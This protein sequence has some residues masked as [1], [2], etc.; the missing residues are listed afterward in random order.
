M[1]QIPQVT[2]TYIS[3]VP[4]HLVLEQIRV[5]A[6]IVL[7][8]VE[9]QDAAD[10]FVLRVELIGEPVHLFALEREIERVEQRGFPRSVLAFE[11]DQRMREV[12]DHRHVEV[13]VDEDRVRK[14]FEEHRMTRRP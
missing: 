10:L 1:P 7:L 11:H 4:E 14:D 8:G 2:V 9:E 13:E 12:H 3:E 6:R 5:V